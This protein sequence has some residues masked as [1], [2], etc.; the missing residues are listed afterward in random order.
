MPWYTIL[1]GALTL[2]YPVLVY[3]GLTHFEPRW[4]APLLLV[5]VL[6]AAVVKRGGS[7]VLPWAMA[8]GALALGLAALLGNSALPLKLYPVAV[9]LALL[10]WFGFSLR[11]G[12]MP[13]VEFLA[14]LRE[15]D[16]PPAG[17]RYTRRVTQLWCAFFIANASM[18]LITVLYM[19]DAAWALY[20]GLIA[21]LL[22]GALM[23]GEWCWRQHLH[24]AQAKAP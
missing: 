14:R 20:N 2:L 16:L 12:G 9:N 23:L 11:K 15:P 13:V 17:V 21:Y 1:L 18:A 6:R 10:G 3:Q 22:I 8:L 5:V 4:L 19:S 7:R 24:R